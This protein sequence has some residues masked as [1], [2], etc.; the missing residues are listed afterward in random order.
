MTVTFDA[1]PVE[2]PFRVLMEDYDGGRMVVT[3]RAIG[4]QGA[5][6]TAWQTAIDRGFEPCVTLAVEEVGE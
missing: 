3:V 6:G 2:R 5:K 1:D 4:E